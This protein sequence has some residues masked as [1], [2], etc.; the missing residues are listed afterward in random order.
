MYY[1]GLNHSPNTLYHYSINL[2][3][4]VR[5]IREMTVIDL[6]DFQP[7]YSLGR[8]SPKWPILCKV[9]C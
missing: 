9:G 1:F 3:V 5:H 4:A 7:R 2:L 8:A 6:T